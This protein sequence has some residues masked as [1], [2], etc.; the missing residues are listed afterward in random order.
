[1]CVYWVCVAKLVAEGVTGV[2]AVRSSSK[3]PREPTPAVC[4]ITEPRRGTIVQQPATAERR[5]RM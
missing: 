4:G 2:A 1:M 3:L 5:G